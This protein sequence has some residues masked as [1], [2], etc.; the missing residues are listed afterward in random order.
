MINGNAKNFNAFPHIPAK[1]MAKK[2]GIE[3]ILKRIQTINNQ[4]RYQVRMG[5]SDLLIKVK[6]QYKDDYR[7]Y[8]TV[9]LEDIDP[10]ETVPDWDLVMTRRKATPP[11]ASA[12]GPLDWQTK[13][14]K[15]QASRSPDDRLAKRSN[16]EDIDDW[17]VAEFLHEFLEGTRTKPK[18]TNLDWN[19]EAALALPEE[20]ELVEDGAVVPQP[21]PGAVS[22]HHAR[23]ADSHQSDLQSD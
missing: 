23:G 22:S 17:Q 5:E 12:S 20:Q 1:A 2:E 10:N 16:R 3:K 15:R 4:L 13:I 11:S 21:N 9:K 19:R 6:Y 8:V 18:Y 7:P 14:G